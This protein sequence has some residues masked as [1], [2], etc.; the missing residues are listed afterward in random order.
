MGRRALPGAANKERR[1]ALRRQLFESQDGLCHLC[2][3]PMTLKRNGTSTSPSFATFD[4]I[5]PKSN[6]G[7]SHHTNLALA[8]RKCNNS[9]G[10]KPL[11]PPPT[12]PEKP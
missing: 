5:E 1:E 2:G 4:H 11:S 10:S 7:R 6:G 12:A 9:R 8:H 3:K